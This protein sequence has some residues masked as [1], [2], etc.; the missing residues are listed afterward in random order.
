METLP[1]PPDDP[2]L[3]SR[4]GVV[5]SRSTASAPTTISFRGDRPSL[6]S[7]A[8]PFVLVLL[9]GA[10]MGG[11]VVNYAYQRSA[12]VKEFFA[13]P[14][15]R[16]R[17]EPYKLKRKKTAEVGPVVKKSTRRTSASRKSR[18]RKPWLGN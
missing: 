1:L 7:R 3:A 16:D 18:D 5:S 14:I 8:S 6:W 4:P 17:N 12:Q 2:V 15:R 13:E 11:S 10:L 9:I